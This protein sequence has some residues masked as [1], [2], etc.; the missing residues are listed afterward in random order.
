MVRSKR[1]HFVACGIAV[2]WLE[3]VA[4]AVA[5]KRVESAERVRTAPLSPTGVPETFFS[6]S[7]LALQFVCRA[8]SSVAWQASAARRPFASGVVEPRNGKLEIEFRTPQ[9]REG[10]VLPIQVAVGESL[11]KIHIFGRDPLADRHSWAESLHLVLFDPPGET[12]KAFDTISL[13]HGQLTGLGGLSAVNEGIV[14]IGEGLSLA[15]HP[16]L[17]DTLCC[18]ARQGVPVILLAPQSG[19][20]RVTDPAPK[21]LELQDESAGQ[22]IDPRIIGD[23]RRSRGLRVSG[24]GNGP[25]LR[26]A[27]QGSSYAWGDFRFDNKRGRL[28]CLTWDLLATWETSPAPRF[29]F[30]RLLEIVSSGKDLSGGKQSE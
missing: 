24:D 23:L 26:I 29:F 15:D 21:R 3:G 22:Q 16:G 19:S 8:P 6:D 11:F 28:C 14:V 9:V 2:L 17:D 4:P 5:Q 18:L 30:V 20:F 13:P 12:A 1:V 7:E 25:L 27:D 10:V